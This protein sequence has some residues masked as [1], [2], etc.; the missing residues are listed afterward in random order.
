VPAEGPPGDHRA[1]RRYAQYR[2]SNNLYKAI[3]PVTEASLRLYIAGN[4]ASSRLAE[5]NLEHLQVMTKAEGWKVEVV[6][7]LARPELAEEA[8]ILATPT[9][10]YE[11]SGRARRIVGDLSDVRR[12]LEFLGI[13]LKGDAA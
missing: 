7:V 12:V 13:E 3:I 1:G 4:S 9:L 2:A 5:K 6:D 8:R 11:Y 10:C